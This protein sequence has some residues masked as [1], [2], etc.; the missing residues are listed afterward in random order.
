MRLSARIHDAGAGTAR[1]GSFLLEVNGTLFKGILKRSG[2]DDSDFTGSV[3][4]LSGVA[5]TV[6]MRK[7]WVQDMLGNTAEYSAEDVEGMRE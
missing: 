7:I 2:E 4:V 5:G 6:K 1:S 3:F